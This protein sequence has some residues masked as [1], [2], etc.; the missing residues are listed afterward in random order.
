MPEY[1]GI[2]DNLRQKV[3]VGDYGIIY[4]VEFRFVSQR[5]K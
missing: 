4:L 3:G 5:R 2:G 1:F